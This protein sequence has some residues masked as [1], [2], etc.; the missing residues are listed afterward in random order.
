MSRA[1]NNPLTM[2]DAVLTSPLVDCCRSCE[3]RICRGR[4]LLTRWRE[5]RRY[6]LADPNRALSCGVRQSHAR[7][8][9]G[10]ELPTSERPSATTVQL[11]SFPLSSILHYLIF[12]LARSSRSSF[13]LST[14]G[15]RRLRTNRRR[16]CFH[17]HPF[18]N[19]L[20]D[21]FPL[22]PLLDRDDQ[23]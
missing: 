16:S 15:T 8:R 2:L 5:R 11:Y 1:L 6:I 7:N 17:S 19:L 10:A 23:F 13:D 4:L 12:H 22:F 9:N 18:H 3:N 14:S 20:A 21:A